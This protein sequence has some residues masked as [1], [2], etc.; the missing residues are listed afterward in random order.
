[1]NWL[2]ITVL[3][4]LVGGLI[5]GLV[6]GF[7]STIYS[8]LATFLI[9]VLTI[10]L[11]PIVVNMLKNNESFHK[12]VYEK[13]DSFVDL[14]KAY[15][16]AVSKMSSKDAPAEGDSEEVVSN[17]VDAVLESFG[18]PSALR[19]AVTKSEG[20]KDY[21]SKHTDEFARGKLKPLE[22]H[23][24]EVLTGAVVN[25]VGFL[26]TFIGVAIV[27]FVVG[28]LLNLIIKIP[29]LKQLNTVLGGAAG[30]FEGLLLVW[31][32]FTIVTMLGTTEFG[33]STLSLINANPFLNFIYEHNFISARLLGLLK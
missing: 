15:D 17:N 19:K 26:I 31:L 32:F 33:Q 28:K 14:E 22:A 1:M 8:L 6:K 2:L 25:A 4:L 3:I 16:N 11:C 20:F 30:L 9:I 7:A 12:S 5:Y 21:V 27:V 10:I 13:I 24:C 29:G 23:V 18:L